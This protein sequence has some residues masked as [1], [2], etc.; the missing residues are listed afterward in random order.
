MYIS[1]MLV[2][3]RRYGPNSLLLEHDPVKSAPR[4]RS[5]EIIY[6]DNSMA[7]A[8]H[9]FFSSLRFPLNSV[10]HFN[11]T[12]DYEIWTRQIQRHYATQ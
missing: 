11:I 1:R 5:S 7:H 4:A 3:I 10:V 6:R 2:P 8:S 12:P 9:P